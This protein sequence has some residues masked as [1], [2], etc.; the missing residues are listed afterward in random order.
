MSDVEDLA[1]GSL[2]ARAPLT[3]SSPLADNTILDNGGTQAASVV[4][5]QA[6]EASGA[7]GTTAASGAAST[8]AVQNES[9]PWALR[10]RSRE[11]SSDPP[12]VTGRR[13]KLR[14]VRRASQRHNTRK[15]AQ[16]YRHI[17]QHKD[18]EI[19]IAVSG[20]CLTASERQTQNIGLQTPMP[21]SSQGVLQPGWRQAACQIQEILGWERA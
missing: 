10:S 2:G 3:S 5:L 18:S 16:F 12:V 17:R 11:S 8:V 4:E 13:R 9:E 15:Q 21:P 19:V 14:R 20:P 6:N 1:S 7:V